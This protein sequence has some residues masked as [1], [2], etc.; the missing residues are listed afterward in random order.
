MASAPQ[1]PTQ[2]Q[3]EDALERT[4]SGWA[5]EL[6]D[7]RKFWWADWTKLIGDAITAV[8]MASP[9]SIV[10]GPSDVRLASEF[11]LPEG[12]FRGSAWSPPRRL[13][14]AWR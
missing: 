4:L 14:P 1:R 8:R 6:D 9:C 5:V 13:L 3:I 12:R 10:G 11:R 2:Q 7:G